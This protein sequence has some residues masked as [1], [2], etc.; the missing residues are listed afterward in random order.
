MPDLNVQIDVIEDIASRLDLR[1]PNRDAVETIA[2]TT[3]QYF[4]VDK[5]ES[6]LE[7]VVDSATGMGK[8]YVLAASIEYFALAD[9]VRNFAVIVPGRT[10]LEK[11]IG[12]F[13]QGHPKSL[14]SGMTT[15]PFVITSDNFN[16][17][18]VRMA[19]DDP[20]VVK[21]F[22]FTVQA[23]IKPKTKA[24]R[25]AHKFQ[26]G[27]GT[28]LYEHLRE[29]ADLVVLADEHH[30]YF[31][32]AFSRAVRDLAPRILLGLTATPHKKTPPEQ[33]IFRYP[34]AAAIAEQYVKTPVLVGRKDDR[35]DSTTKLTDGLE[36]LEQKSKAL[37]AYCENSGA[38][39][40]NPVMLV[41][42]QTIEDADEYEN[43]L[44]S[45]AFRQ[46]AYAES[47]LVIHSNKPDDALNALD[48]VEQADSPIRVIVSV[49]MLKEGW[50]V[51]NVYVIASMRASV[52]EILTEQTLG[53]GLRLPFGEYTGIEFLDTLEVLAHERYED[54]L[55]KA[56]VINEAFV[57]HRTRAALKTSLDGSPVVV[58]Q[59]VETTTNAIAQEE[60]E[61]GYIADA[62]AS[63]APIISSVK[64]RTGH[65]MEEAFRMQAAIVSQ[66]E[67][68]PIEVPR[69]RQ[70]IVKSYF[71]LADI[72]DLTTFQL[73]GQRIAEDPDELLR[74][75]KLGARVLYGAHGMRR[76]ELVTSPAV[77]EIK[78]QQIKIPLEDSVRQLTQTLLAAPMIPA[79]K[80]QRAQAK[81]II[82]AFVGGLG[83]KAESVLSGYFER[84][85]GRL[86]E[87]VAKEQKK[88]MPPP[89]YEDVVEVNIIGGA[90]TNDRATSAD[91]VGKFSKRIAYE[92]WKKSIY[93]IE[94]FD[95]ST[96]RTFAG[97]VDAASQVAR[98]V[99]LHRGDLPILWRIDGREYNADFIVI[100][101]NQTHWVV[102]VKADKDISSDEVLAKRQAAKRWANHVNADDKIQ[103]TWRYLLVSETD[104][105]QAKDSWKALKSFGKN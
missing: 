75:T 13:T 59:S 104:I 68:E 74:R 30:T 6:P 42:A 39:P 78:A 80:E 70:S 21:L 43:V 14:L 102:E 71:D 19:M 32:P 90:R 88:V 83:E 47:V 101:N 69:L 25:K 28:A 62:A 82:Q 3:F 41:V 55:K 65:V 46:G 8:T 72:T 23:I 61:T 66:E 40:V 103:V 44:T 48:E 9:G 60:D 16:T 96:E 4:D 86:I 92:G 27:L 53:R 54:L 58:S 2:Y 100:E 87:A 97:V 35:N 36:L 1:P 85:A 11:T 20:T 99:R 52:S 49:G 95:S 7:A 12:N 89:K 64:N 26:E 81:P 50:D 10:I 56:G 34:L 98:W 67:K 18:I 57:D 22:V 76:T 63:V 94:W 24:G 31:G 38:E 37:A 84:A 79:R 105:A 77:D 5:G 17:P 51:K 73:L 15:A 33:I 93:P 91:R 29:S 45:N